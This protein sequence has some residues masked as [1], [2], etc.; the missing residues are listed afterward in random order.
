VTGTFKSGCPTGCSCRMLLWDSSKQR[1]ER[2]TPANTEFD[3]C[4]YLVEGLGGP[5]A[6]VL[7]IRLLHCVVRDALENWG[8]SCDL[9]LD[10]A[11]ET[12]R[13]SLLF[14]GNRSAEIGQTFFH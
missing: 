11:S 6:D 14:G 10:Q 2:A 4:G 3:L 12:R 7:G 13:C 9:R 5:N 1:Q 8:P